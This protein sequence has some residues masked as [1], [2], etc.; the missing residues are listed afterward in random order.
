[1]TCLLKKRNKR[2]K[3]RNTL[4]VDLLYSV[5]NPRKRVHSRE[6]KVFKGS[7]VK[8]NNVKKKPFLLKGEIFNLNF[9]NLNYLHSCVFFIFQPLSHDCSW[10]G[11]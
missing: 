4:A 8:V 10:L 5:V 1:M 7:E 9:I 11:I 2:K 3:P 6:R